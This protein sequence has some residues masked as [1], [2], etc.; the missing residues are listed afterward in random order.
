MTLRAGAAK[1]GLVGP[2]SVSAACL[3]L[4]SSPLMRGGNRQVALIALEAIA[5]VILVGLAA[6]TH[7]GTAAPRSDTVATWVLLSSPLL[8]AAIY[9]LPVPMA[10]WSRVPGRAIY[11]QAMQDAGVAA[12]AWLP[13]SVVPDATLAS[14]LAG[15]PLV[16]AFLLG[17]RC[18]VTQLKLLARVVV[19]VALGQVLFGLMQI[20]G[21]VLSPLYFGAGG[22]RPIGTFA[23]SNH[24]A[25]YLTTALI[26][27]V[28][29]GWL[30][31]RHRSRTR[32]SAAEA[33]RHWIVLWIVG[34][35]LLVLGVLMSRSRGAALTGVPMAALG[36]AWAM[37]AQAD[38]RY[39][40]RAV[41]ALV[42]AILLG[43][44]A[45]LGLDAIVSRYAPSELASSASFRAALSETTL[46][47]AA[48][49][50]PV[51]AGWGVFGAVY[52]R[53]QPG[54]I[55]G[56]AGYAHQDYLQ[57]LFE[58]GVFA[59]VVAAAFAWL[60]ARRA[61]VLLRLVARAGHLRED[62]VAAALCGL[63]LLGFLLHSL[64][65]FNMHIPANA[66]LAS[67]LAGVFLRPLADSADAP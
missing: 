28:W 37:T 46:A 52:P 8:L 4:A 41:A 30:A 5:L 54:S 67:L 3:L 1:T 50:W 12:P 34:G 31:Q 49:F 36:L 44:V 2:V 29:L 58:G 39:G 33:G 61:V 27:Y 51:G 55:P 14:L 23:N 60:V 19:A 35:L 64:V 40:K 17:R 45:F 63:G 15:I 42:A 66:I 57:M 53:F 32:V 6:S 18:A 16:A 25:N 9:L 13:L 65:E 20:S 22:G 59:L 7:R 48:Q 10:I 26:L 47:G 11:L 62:T 24:Y 38:T 43:A 56:F 21:G